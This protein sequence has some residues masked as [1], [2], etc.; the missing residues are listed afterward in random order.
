MCNPRVPYRNA[1]R[2]NV[3]RRKKNKR[4]IK[5]KRRCDIRIIGGG[6]GKEAVSTSCVSCSGKREKGR[7]RETK[8]RR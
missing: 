8:V 1:R 7:K 6:G 5:M 3:S 4:W 2:G